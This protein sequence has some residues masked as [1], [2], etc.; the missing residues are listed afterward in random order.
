MTFPKVGISGVVR[1]WDDAERTGV[2]GA[3]VKA[4]LNVGGVPTIL[5][6]LMGARLASRALDGV[7]ALVLTGGEDIDPA[8]Y[9]A[10]PSDRLSPPSRER[11]LFELALFAAARQRGLPILG[12]CR[13][14]QLINVALGGTLYQDLPT[15]RPGNIE[16]RP[17]GPRDSRTHQVRL[18]VGSRAA[19]TLGRTEVRVNSSHH[20]AIRDLPSGLIASGWT[21]DGLIEA[22]E[23]PEGAPWLLAVQWHPE[24]M[25]AEAAAPERGLFAALVAAATMRSGSVDE[26]GEQ[27]PITDAIEGG[28]ERREAIG[29]GT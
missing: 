5:S 21:D 27:H 26:G 3:Y 10:A 7:E 14:I 17:E 25:H 9:G 22:V 11:D 6:P 12:I 23:T 2:N 8:L 15:E 29:R 4:V 18:K 1:Q 19:A 16:H 20:Q 13:G 28:S 24:E